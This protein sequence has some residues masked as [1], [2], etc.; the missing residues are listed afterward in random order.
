MM[1][2]EIQKK[3]DAAIR[4]VH[5]SNLPAMEKASAEAFISR[6]AEGTNGLELRE[7]VQ[8]MSE[9]LFRIAVKLELDE[10]EKAKDSALTWKGK[11]LQALVQAK[12]QL[13]ILGLG[14]LGFLAL[15][16]DKLAVL[17][18]LF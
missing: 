5:E 6:A 15:N 14:V 2:D 18:A 11:L 9:V 3:R 1:T 10:V 16:P 4:Q 17:L 12:W 8:C 13:T 7:K